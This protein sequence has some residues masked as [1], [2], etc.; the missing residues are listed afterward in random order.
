M[1]INNIQ[2]EILEHL[3]YFT[4]LT[5]SQLAGLTG[6]SLSYLREQLAI[7]KHRKYIR[8]YH[9]E[10]ATKVRAENMYFLTKEG[11]TALQENDKIFTELR[12]PIGTPLFVRDYFHRKHYTDL[13]IS[14][15]QEFRK[16]DIAI[17]MLYSYFDKATSNKKNAVLQGKTSI[18][19]GNTFFMP[20]GIMITKE[21][22]ISTLYLLELHNGKDTQ[23]AL[24]HTIATH[25]LAIAQGSPGKTFGIQANPFVLCA[26]EFEGCK[27]AV[28]KR[29]QQNERFLPLQQFFYFASLE[30]I[31][32][33]CA[34]AW[35]TIADEPLVFR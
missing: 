30:D 1:L 18:P 10:V 9:V 14:I 29:L 21:N 19:V 28:I 12:V 35:H 6:K 24:Q 8:S 34:N 15:V 23:R 17:P 16:R 26:F 20:D 11:A 31:I 3:G 4:Y 25:T 32:K 7:L 5:V 33:N 2:T 22:N 13:L 27:Q